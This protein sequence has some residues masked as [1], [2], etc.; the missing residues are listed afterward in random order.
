VSRLLQE[1]VLPQS[2]GRV[3]FEIRVAI[4]ALELV[5]RQLALAGEAEQ[6]EQQR[7]ET[8]LGRAGD[9][10]ELNRELCARIANGTIP[11]ED[12]ALLDHLWATTLEKLAVDQ[13]SYAAFRA[14]QQRN[15]KG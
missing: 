4:N 3:A 7:V 12:Q 6:C 13:P 14:E 8:L 5:A 15:A 2:S 1:T 11:L 10:M 9:L